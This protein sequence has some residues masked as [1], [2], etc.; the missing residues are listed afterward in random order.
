MSG[1]AKDGHYL[2][3]VMMAAVLSSA[4]AGVPAVFGAI[5]LLGNQL[6]MPG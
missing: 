4:P 2:I 5:E 6:P 3:G 1:P